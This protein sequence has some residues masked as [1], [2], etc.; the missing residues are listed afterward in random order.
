[1]PKV[2]SICEIRWLAIKQH[3][4]MMIYISL[5]ARA[6]VTAPTPWAQERRDS[7]KCAYLIAGKWERGGS[8]SPRAPSQ[9]PL[10]PKAQPAAAANTLHL[11]PSALLT[12][13]W[14]H[15]DLHPGAISARLKSLLQSRPTSTFLLWQLQYEFL[16][17]RSTGASHPIPEASDKP[18]TP[19]CP[20]LP[21]PTVPCVHISAATL[22][23]S[24][25]IPFCHLGR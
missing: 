9:S 2:P 16:P 7:T 6:I 17:V 11:W 24:C 20:A 12:S 15:G 14:R 21:T 1:M 23:K 5:F 25:G 19:S 10:M 4:L 13:T 22:P 8:W 18:P 3:H